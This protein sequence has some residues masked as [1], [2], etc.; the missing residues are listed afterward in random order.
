ML[1]LLFNIYIYSNHCIDVDVV[2]NLMF[3]ML[4]SRCYLAVCL[5]FA[6]C[7]CTWCVHLHIYTYIC[8][9]IYFFSRKRT[10]IIYAMHKINYLRHQKVY[11]LYYI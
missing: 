8:I 11:Y 2:V 3:L 10:C 1:M 7:C 6:L 4:F 5:M 9:C